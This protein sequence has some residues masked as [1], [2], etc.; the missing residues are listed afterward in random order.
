MNRNFCTYSNN[1]HVF[2]FPSKFLP[3]ILSSLTS[4][5]AEGRFSHFLFRIRE[6][7]VSADGAYNYIRYIME[8]KDKPP[9]QVIHLLFGKKLLFELLDANEHA[10]NEKQLPKQRKARLRKLKTA[11]YMVPSDR[12]WACIISSRNLT[13]IILNI[14]TIIMA[15]PT[16]ICTS[17]ICSVYV[18]CG[19]CRMARKR[20]PSLLA[21]RQPA[22]EPNGST[23]PLP[24]KLL[25][26]NT[27]KICLVHLTEVNMS[28]GTKYIAVLP[29][30]YFK[31]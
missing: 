20:L 11:Y 12:N 18:D 16:K 2:T 29:G 28:H 4:L 3:S 5:K 1:K 21:S 15:L 17:A 23:D 10:I 19:L 27:W 6:L 14:Q 9:Y 25:E 24:R 30:S 31:N 26:L 22:A 13:L 7:T 8:E